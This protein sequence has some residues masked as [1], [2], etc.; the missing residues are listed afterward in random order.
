[1]TTRSLKIPCELDQIYKITD[2]VGEAAR[3]AG[4]D[5]KT[6]YACQLA[7]CEACENIILHGFG[8][9]G[10]E[11]EIEIQTKA[12]SGHLTI[13]LIDEAP[14]FNPSEPKDFKEI[15]IENP[16][17]GGLGLSIIHRTMD[18]VKYERRDEKNILTLFK[19]G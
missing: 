14:P 18:E 12:T 9:S 7:I 19:R 10:C 5:H 15:D 11:S 8:N 16:P 4:F 6:L 3:S 17:D 13:K 2:L 1:M